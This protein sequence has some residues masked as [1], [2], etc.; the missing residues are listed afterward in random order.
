M[1]NNLSK[2]ESKANKGQRI[3]F[4]WLFG[5]FLQGNACADWRSSHT[6]FTCV[7]MG[8]KPR[9]RIEQLLKKIWQDLREKKCSRIAH[10]DQGNFS[11][12]IK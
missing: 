11:T 2:K 6:E 12:T 4:W 1:I 10:L 3:R 8:V 9:V 7:Q 5:Q